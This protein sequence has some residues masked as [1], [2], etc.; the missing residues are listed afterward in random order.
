MPPHNDPDW[1]DVLDIV[2]AV[3]AIVAAL[4]TA[5]LIADWTGVARG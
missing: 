3:A 4:A 1:I 5:Y 2:L